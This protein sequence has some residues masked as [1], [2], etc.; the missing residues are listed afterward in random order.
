MISYKYYKH[1]AAIPILWVAILACSNN[2][3]PS[4]SHE[5]T[6]QT[7]SSSPVVKNSGEILFEAKCSSCHGVDGSAGIGNAANLQT[8]KMDSA[9]VERTIFNGKNGMPSFRNTL[10][11]TEIK[12]LASYVQTLHR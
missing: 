11:E 1:I 6:N 10:S 12:Q 2:T 7:Q 5:E 4:S 3:E 9:T 8:S